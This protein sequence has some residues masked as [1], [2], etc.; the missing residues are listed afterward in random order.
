MRLNTRAMIQNYMEA[1]L[2][3]FLEQSWKKWFD[4]CMVFK[5]CFFF[6]LGFSKPF[7]IQ[8]HTNGVESSGSPA[9]TNNRGFCLNYV[10]QPCTSTTTGWTC[11]LVTIALPVYD[12]WLK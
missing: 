10:E 7:I 9:D 4:V 8:V 2:T 1:N 5:I 3:K 6:F 12:N 11:L